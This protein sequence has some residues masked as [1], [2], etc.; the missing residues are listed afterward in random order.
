MVTPGT[1]TMSLSDR[2]AAKVCIDPQTGCHRWTGNTCR[3]Y[4]CINVRVG[5]GRPGT[6]RATRVVY[7]LK[8][9]LIP[10]GL[11]LDHVHARGCR[12]RDCV[13]I[14][15][16]E[17]VTRSENNRRGRLGRGEN[18][19]AAKVRCPRGHPFDKANTYVT[20]EGKRQCRTCK[21]EAQRRYVAN[22][23]Q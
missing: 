15:H 1:E 6:R 20:P 13:N 14:E 18:A 2:I 17:P 7:E 12:Y 16:L 19:Q 23:G 5:E 4:A 11:D 22:R 10:P 3:G 8:V 21:R 9:G